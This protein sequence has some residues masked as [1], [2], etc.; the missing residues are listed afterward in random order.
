MSTDYN[1]ELRICYKQIQQ[2]RL[3]FSFCEMNSCE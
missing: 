1:L 2:L 3:K